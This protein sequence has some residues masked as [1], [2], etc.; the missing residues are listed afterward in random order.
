VQQVCRKCAALTARMNCAL[1]RVCLV[2]AVLQCFAGA[3]LACGMTTH[4]E[5]AHRAE[6]S[7]IA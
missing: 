4:T 3:V 1:L 6:V 2:V 7:R 5:I